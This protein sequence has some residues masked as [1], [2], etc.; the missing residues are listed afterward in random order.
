MLLATIKGMS[1]NDID[2]YKQLL[3][4]YKNTM[5]QETSEEDFDRGMFRVT[6]LNKFNFFNL[7]VEDPRGSGPENQMY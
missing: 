3:N 1:E 6:E 5:K 2:I 4:I 7:L